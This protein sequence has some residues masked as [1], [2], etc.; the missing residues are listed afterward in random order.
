MAIVTS[1]E[2]LSQTWPVEQTA[3]PPEP[4]LIRVKPLPLRPEEL[5][6]AGTSMGCLNRSK[7]LA[8]RYCSRMLPS[9]SASVTLSFW[10]VSV[11]PWPPIQTLPLPVAMP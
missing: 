3:V 7:P 9:P 10:S 6:S 2:M 11:V 5:A 1:P 8:A 4:A